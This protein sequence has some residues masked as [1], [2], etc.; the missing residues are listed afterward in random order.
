MTVQH[1][2]ASAAVIGLGTMGRGITKLL[3]AH[4]ISTRG[5]DSQLTDVARQSLVEA[6]GVQLSDSLD[7]ALDGADIVFEAVSEDLVVKEPLLR[8]ISASTTAVIATNTS[9]FVPSV[10]ADFTTSPER[11]LAIHFFNPADVVPLVEIIPHPTTAQPVVE[12]MTQLMRE[13]SMRPVVLH[14]ERQ[15]FVANRLQAAI[16]RESLALVEEG[17]V[18]PEALDDVIKSG[19]APRWAVAGVIGVADLGG[20]DIFTAVCTQLFPELNSAKTPVSLLT[21]LPA[22]G[23]LG[24]KSGSGFYKHTT[25]SSQSAAA[26]MARLF[27]VLAHEELRYGPDRASD[28]SVLP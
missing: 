20:L 21:D 25:T 12:R 16:L 15:G 19:L 27:A 28:A 18:T 7:D 13:L 5:F 22:A 17:V 4:G 11:F 2:V 3:A 9:T 1:G 24:A 26:K 6:E 14:K 10:L 8:A 23:R